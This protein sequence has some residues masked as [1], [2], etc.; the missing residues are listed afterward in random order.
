MRKSVLYLSI[1]VVASLLFA[2]GGSENSKFLDEKFSRENVLEIYRN[3]ETENALSPQEIALLNDGLNALGARPDTLIGMTPREVIEYQRELVKRKNFKILKITSNRVAMSM[4]YSVKFLGVKA[5]I[6]TIRKIKVNTIGY[7]FYNKGENAIKKVKGWL[8]FYNK[9]GQIVKQF[10][11]DNSAPI[12]P[13]DSLTLYKSFKYEE[14][15]LRDS[16]IRFNWT[17]MIA[18]W[19]PI[20]LQFPDGRTL[21]IN[22]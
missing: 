3:L 2:C 13:K 6:D 10:L 5:M 18:K 4:Y 21:K 8:Q 16:L 1:V 22:D 9:K 12:L 19:E 20:E 7:Q 17:S 15:S 11:L 14:G